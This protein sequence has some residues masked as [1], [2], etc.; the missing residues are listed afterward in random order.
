MSQANRLSGALL[1]RILNRCRFLFYGLY[2]RVVSTK[3]L[4]VGKQGTIKIVTGTSHEVFRAL[5]FFRKEPETLSWIDSFPEASKSSPVLFDVG[6]NIGIYSLYAAATIPQATILSFEPESQSFASLCRNV[7]INGF[8][9]ITPY[10]FALSDEVGIGDLHISTMSAGAGAAALG[11]D[12]R[13][14]KVTD[15]RIVRQGV[16]VTSLDHL[17]FELGLPFPNYIKIDV[18]GI[19]KKILAGARRVLADPRLRGLLVELQY[20]S[21]ADISALAGMLAGDGLVMVGMSV[22]EGH[23]GSGL[24]S[25]NFIFRRPTAG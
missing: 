21:D 24:N 15:R 22:W 7:G 6:A 12:Y 20:E 4:K 5:T 23:Y 8:S 17:V 18:D 1:G 2:A 19:E 14:L 11:E 3:T 16:F 9:N 25:R 10:Q 13:F